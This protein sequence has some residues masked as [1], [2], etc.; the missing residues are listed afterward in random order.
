MPPSTLRVTVAPATEPAKGH[1]VSEYAGE[2]TLDE[3]WA[4]L[5]DDP[6]SVLV[7]VRTEAE[8]HFVGIPV[9]DE[10][11]REP[12]FVELIRHPGGAHNP[13]FLTQVT[14]G[15]E[16][17]RPILLLCRSGA[18]SLAAAKGLTAAGYGPAWNIT[19]G[20]EGPLDDDGHRG[21]GWRHSG[22]P[23]RQS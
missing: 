17:G 18:R 5:R 14:D 11:G 6:S 13:D 3:A 1:G 10:L 21:S 9:L 22:L 15:L 8:W 19:A 12:R 20:F 2:L 7:D 23:W 16:P 4:M